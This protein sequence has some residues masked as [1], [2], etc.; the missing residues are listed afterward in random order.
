MKKQVGLIGLFCLM[1]FSIKAQ[2][3]RADLDSIILEVYSNYSDIPGII[4]GVHHPD[5]GQFILPFGVEK[6]GDTTPIDTNAI[7]G[8][9]SV[10]KN[11]TWVLMHRLHQEGL[12]DIYDIAYYENPVGEEIFI[13][14]LQDTVQ[15]YQGRRFTIADLMKH[16]SGIVDINDSENYPFNVANDLEKKFTLGE[17]LKHLFYS[18]SPTNECDS[19]TSGM[20]TDFEIGVDHQYS[21]YGPMVAT[22]IAEI[23]TDK[24][25][26]ELEKEYIFEAIGLT[27]TSQIAFDNPIGNLTFGHDCIRDDDGNYTT[28]YNVLEWY[29]DDEN[30]NWQPYSIASIY[31]YPIYS[32]VAD[33]L[34]YLQA[35]FNDESF[36]SAEI[37]AA[38]KSDY[39]LWFNIFK[40]GLGIIDYDFLWSSN[41]PGDD[42]FGHTGNG[43]FG[44]GTSIAHRSSDN[45]S[46]VVFTNVR[47][48]TSQYEEFPYFDI[49]KAIGEYFWE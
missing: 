46:V 2:S 12:I 28:E 25:V 18:N 38:M 49:T 41:Q 39:V 16:S 9:G 20:C 30:L 29:D 3:V 1:F 48:S 35:Q 15:K 45:L 19:V 44:H 26:L 24:D 13:N 8:V 31:R 22:V 27:S 10:N 36:L 34:L 40:S 43:T 23:E 47:P 21:S 5:Y 33:L 11:F 17:A 32:N 6:Y 14:Q 37:L 42:F 4:V 7:F